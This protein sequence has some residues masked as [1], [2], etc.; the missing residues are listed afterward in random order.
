M[1]RASLGRYARSLSYGDV[2]RENPVSTGYLAYSW[3]DLNHDKFVQPNEVNLGDFL[4]NDS[5]DPANPG[6]VS[7]SPNKVDRNPKANHDNEFIVGIDRSLDP[8]FV[9]VPAYT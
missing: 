6:A 9:Q 7:S 3:N 5:I 1:L 2:S 8:N 4:Y